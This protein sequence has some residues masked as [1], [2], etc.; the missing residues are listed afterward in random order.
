[1]VSHDRRRSRRDRAAARGAARSGVRIDAHNGVPGRWRRIAELAISTAAALG[2]DEE[3]ARKL[4]L[5]CRIYGAGEV[6]SGPVDDAFDPLA[7][8][9]IEQ[10][11]QEAVA[12]A[13]LAAPFAALR[14]A[15]EIVAARG[16]WFDGSGKPHGRKREAVPAE[17]G[18]LA[19]A[20]AYDRLDEKERLETAA[21]G[22]QFDPAIVRAVMGARS[23]A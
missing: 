7:R 12:A 17:S 5:A 21:A 1:V 6:E 20:I 4:R 8:L 19:A 2:L 16:E 22:L 11:A 10:R 18:I 15:A 3:R 23:R 14:D 9:G 13:A